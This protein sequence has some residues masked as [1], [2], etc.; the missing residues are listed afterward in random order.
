MISFF[1]PLSNM[2]LNDIT[3]INHNPE[4]F[5]IF[6]QAINRTGKIFDNITSI[7]KNC[8]INREFPNLN[9][10]P[11]IFLPDYIIRP[12]KWGQTCATNS[13]QMRSLLIF[14]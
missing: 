6:P 9:N 2:F 12:G 7:N 1:L 3:T 4:S 8:Y 13:K 14:P 10:Q 5:P 11:E